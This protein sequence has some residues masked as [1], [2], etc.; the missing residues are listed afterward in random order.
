MHLGNL[1]IRGW[2]WAKWGFIF[3]ALGDVALWMNLFN[4]NFTCLS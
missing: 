4:E 1:D 3:D 2:R